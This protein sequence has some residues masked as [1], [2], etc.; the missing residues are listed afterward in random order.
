MMILEIK[1]LTKTFQGPVKTITALNGISL[2][3]DRGE[4]VVV[5][6]PSGCGKTTLLLTAGTLLRP[7]QGQV[8]VNGKDPY[9]MSAE[10]R[11]GFRA[12]AIGFVFQQFYLI[13]YLT[14][15]ENILAPA[16]AKPVKHAKVRTMELIGKFNLESRKDHVP[17]ALSTGERQR[18]ALARALL[19]EPDLI[20]AD[21]PTGN[22]DKDNA[23]VV[24]NHL[25]DMARAGTA[26]L[27]VTHEAMAEARAHRVLRL[28][29][30]E[31][32]DHAA[33]TAR[34]TTGNP[35]H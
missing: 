25:T 24:L 22:L 21:E 15:M 26:V 13:P 34:P 14:V 28:A 20:L 10:Q 8:L 18:T 19:H 11:S 1:E 6:G 32:A 5:T 3:V 2:S 17:A 7:G 31:H 12:Q 29:G 23:M 9:R 16:V 35:S 27:M 30:G 33:E 4:L